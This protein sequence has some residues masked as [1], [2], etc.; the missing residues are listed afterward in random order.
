M[1]S[2]LLTP[3]EVA[4]HLLLK[5]VTVKKY[6]RQGELKGIKIGNRWRIKESELQN[7]LERQSEAGD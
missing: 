2:K 5:P 7:F 6:L 1:P 4:E 3:Q